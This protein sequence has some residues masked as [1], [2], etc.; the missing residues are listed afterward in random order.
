MFWMG[1]SL[2]QVSKHPALPQVVYQLCRSCRKKQ[3]AQAVHM[4]PLSLF[5]L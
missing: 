4:I 1:T 5:C 2:A 3:K